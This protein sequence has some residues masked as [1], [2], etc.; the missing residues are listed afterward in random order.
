MGA[1]DPALVGP[2]GQSMLGHHL[3]A[4]A[5]EQ[6]RLGLADPDLAAE[7]VSPNDT[8]R[9]VNRKVREYL[10]GGVRV[11]WLVYPDEAEVQVRTPGGDDR[12]LTR[13]DTL[14]GDP[15]VPGFALPL[16]DLFPPADP[17]PA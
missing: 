2:L 12:T 14:T 8:A 15:V 10:R 3:V 16:A 9:E 17:R 11:V 7:V 1:D 13:G 4:D 5:D 6:A